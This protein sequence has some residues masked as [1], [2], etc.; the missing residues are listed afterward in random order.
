MSKTKLCNS[1][2]RTICSD[3]NCK[4]CHRKSFASNPKSKFW[5]SE[6]KISPRNVFKSSGKK[7]KFNCDSCNHDF[8]IMLSD[9][10]NGQFCPFCASKKLC[11]NNKCK[12]CEKKSFLSHPK[13]EFFSSSNN[14]SPRQLFRSSNKKYI[15]DCPKCD[16]SF[17]ASLI[18]ITFN[19]SFCP[20][21]AHLRLCQNMNCQF[22]KDKSFASHPKAIY[23]SSEN[24][25]SPRFAFKSSPK[26][27]KFDCNKCKHAF[28]TSLLYISQ[29]NCFCPFCAHTKLCNGDNCDLCYQNSFASHEKAKYWS[30]ENKIS[31]R[32]A[33]KSSNKKYKFDCNKCNHAFEINLSC[34]SQDNCFCPFCAHTK[35]CNDDNCDSCYQKSFAS[36]EKAIYWSSEN[37]ISPR[38]VF[39][40]STKKY[41]FD[42]PECN[43]IYETLLKSVSSGRWCSCQINKT[44]SKLSNFLL[45]KKIK[46]KTQAKFDWCKRKVKLRFD[47]YIED[48]NL[49]IELDGEQHFSQV[50]NWVNPIKTQNNDMYKMKCANYNGISVI[51][52]M[53]NDVWEN[54]NNWDAKL[55]DCIKKYQIPVNIYIGHK[56]NNPYLKIG[57]LYERPNNLNFFDELF[58][59]SKNINLITKNKYYSKILRKHGYHLHLHFYL[60][61]N[62]YFCNSLKTFIKLN[63]PYKNEKIGAES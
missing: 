35:L 8:E 25:I 3:I 45:S 15:F 39:K 34:I 32:F 33:F 40:S 51:R 24:K 16:H 19:D 60:M 42:C 7:Y 41:K 2:K 46:F 13:A 56:Y 21:C 62:F 59:I 57:S 53:Q 63:C 30:S 22:C 12:I 17:E 10:S 28:E 44:E 36:Y 20:Y 47:F 18:N 27:Y 61:K 50:S 58:Y 23:W 6:N 4:I 1:T 26:K 5:S 54:R 31:P 55:L 52:I 37:K 11:D 29:D 9:V 48:I 49:I 43:H 14:I 38:N